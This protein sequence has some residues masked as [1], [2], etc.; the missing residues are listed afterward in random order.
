MQEMIVMNKRILFLAG[1][2]A[3]LPSCLQTVADLRT[4]PKHQPQFNTP[5]PTATKAAEATPAAPVTKQQKEAVVSSQF[6]DINK[7]FR[8]LYGRVEGV[9]NQMN[10]LKDGEKEKAMEARIAQLE[11]KVSLLETTVADLHAKAKKE[12]LTS[13]SSDAREAANKDDMKEA[14]KLFDG[15]KWADAI[16]AFEEYRKANPKGK[17]YTEATYKIGLCFQN[18]GMKDD[19]K[20]FFKEVVDKYPQSKEAGLAKS[21]LKKL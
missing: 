10:Q 4:D 18:M 3:V 14:K 16:L 2:L 1:A 13:S 5:A 20:A 12:M 9:E 17:Y 6:D 21:K 7:D 19:A 8:E 15:K 11:T